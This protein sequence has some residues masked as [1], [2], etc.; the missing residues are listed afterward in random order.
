MVA[1]RLGGNVPPGER[2]DGAELCIVHLTWQI[3][4]DPAWSWMK[5]VR[6]LPEADE[7]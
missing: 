2:V 3:E 6:E 1:L 7:D 4:S 5:F